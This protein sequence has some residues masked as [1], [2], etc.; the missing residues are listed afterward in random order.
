MVLLAV[1]P[2]LMAAFTYEEGCSRECQF[3]ITVG[4][5]LVYTPQGVYCGL[6]WS[7]DFSFWEERISCTSA[8][9]TSLG[10][11]DVLYEP[12]SPS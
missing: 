11:C 3:C 9:M 12:Y 8:G 2:R 1:E 5:V 6:E 7:S 10:A 4:T